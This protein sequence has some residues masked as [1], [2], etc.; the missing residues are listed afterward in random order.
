MTLPLKD[1]ETR[2][3]TRA[4]Q[5]LGSVKIVICDRG[6]CDLRVNYCTRVLLDSMKACTLKGQSGLQL[7]PPSL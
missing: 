2:D 1:I 3:I 4:S 5:S 7:P 6:D